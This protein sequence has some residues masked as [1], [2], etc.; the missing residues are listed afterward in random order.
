MVEKKSF[1]VVVCFCVCL[2]VVVVVVVWR[3]VERE[4]VNETKLE[5][6]FLADW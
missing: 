4:P 5:P 6:V 3:E 1:V 2:F